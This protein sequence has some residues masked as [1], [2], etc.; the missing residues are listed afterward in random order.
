MN[1]SGWS[2]GMA[3]RV[4]V[5]MCAVIAS[6]TATSSAQAPMAPV[7]TEPPRLPAILEIDLMTGPEM[8][9]A[10]REEGKTTALVYNGGTEQRGPHNVNGGHN[11]MGRETALAIARK[12]GHA[13]VAPILPY[14]VEDVDPELPGTI[15][16]S[17]GTFA[18]VNAELTEQL[19]KNGFKTVVLMGDHGGGQRQLREVAEKLDLTHRDQGV[20]VFYCGDVYSK[21]NRD[22][23]AWLTANGYPLSV[24]AG[25]P[26]TSEM[27]YLG[28]GKDWVRTELLPIAVDDSATGSRPQ[29]APSS[30]RAKNGINGD[31]RH[32]S[33]E[34]GRRLFEMRVD[35]AVTQINGLIAAR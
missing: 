22:F 7:P 18:L 21:A 35:Y 3:V 23:D 34:L 17:A 11:L 8:R 19:I 13:L 29:P 12:L 27:M 28:A 33:P 4:P 25:L 30:Y 5:L 16:L 32:S 26:D 31:A 6:L 14:A 1:L 9:R 15:G 2:A 24:H 10:I 20:R